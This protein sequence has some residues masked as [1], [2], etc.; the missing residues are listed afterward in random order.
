MN[1]KLITDSTCCIPKEVLDKEKIAYLE[2]QLIIDKK[3]YRDLSDLDYEE[4]IQSLQF[5]EPYPKSSLASPQ[6]A[7]KLFEQ[8]QKEGYKEILYIGLSPNVSNQFNS[9]KVAAKRFK[10]KI[11]I[12]LYQSGLMGPSQGAMVWNALKLLKDGKTVE[13]ITAYLD[14]IKDQVY[15]V[16]LSA[17]FNTLFRTGK[18]KKGVGITVIAS[19]LSLKPLFEINLDQGVVGIGG[20]VGYRGAI[21]KV[22]KNISIHRRAELEYD[23]YISD[24]IA[25]RKL[26]FEIVQKVKHN[27]PIKDIHYWRIS[28]VVAWALGKGSVM[29]TIAP[30]MMS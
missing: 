9:A 30:T 25:P 7:Y 15:T 13:E 1:I 28:P 8:A 2:S 20:G 3:E 19:V 10:N 5:L 26:I 22:L 18:I 14:T 27:F 29:I 23:L 6:D 21:K 24:A 11:K 17:D 16:G 12:T 4:V